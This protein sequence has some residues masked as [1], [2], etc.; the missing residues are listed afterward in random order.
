MKRGTIR[1][2]LV[3]WLVVLGMGAEIFGQDPSQKNNQEEEIFRVTLIGTGVPLVDPDR[4]GPSVLVEVANNKFLFDVGRGASINIKKHGLELAEITAVFLTHM[5]GDHILGLPDVWRSSYRPSNGNR[6]G[7]LKIFGPNGVSK[8][9]AGLEAIY[10]NAWPSDI[11]KE[12]GF[13]VTEFDQEGVLFHEGAL[14]VTAFFV[15]HGRAE[16]YGFKI[17]YR[18]K[19]VVISGDTAYSENLIKH[20]TGTNLLVHE[21][22]MADQIMDKDRIPR[23]R[24]GHTIDEDAAK[25][26]DRA[27]PEVAVA[28]HL[29][30]ESKKLAKKMK[31]LYSG[32]FYAGEDMMTF[33]LG[34]KVKMVK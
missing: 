32:K 15:D 31:R 33:D 13:I 16:A 6:Q 21:V 25:V 26:F 17:E 5:H 29:G 12:P 9:A 8:M 4:M 28:Y 3:F 2:I 18:G 11:V 14:K 23:L 30:V 24:N 20:A 10:K 1:H 22:F 19:S 7:P 27:K 34:A